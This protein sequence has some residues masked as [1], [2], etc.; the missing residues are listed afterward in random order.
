MMRLIIVILLFVSLLGCEEPEPVIPAVSSSLAADSSVSAACKQVLG[1]LDA[2]RRRATSP[3]DIP[4]EVQTARIV[5][6]TSA[7]EAL[8]SCK[9]Q[10]LD[11]ETTAQMYVNDALLV[12]L[13]D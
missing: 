6:F 10:G 12:K 13:G 3:S 1:S 7:K 8:V 5:Y 2:V 4:G 11:A 9:G